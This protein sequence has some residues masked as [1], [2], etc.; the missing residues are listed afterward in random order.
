MSPQQVIEIYQAVSRLMSDMAQAAQA[1]SWERLRE[2]ESQCRTLTHTLMVEEANVEL[3]AELRREKFDL[4]RR[5]LDDDAAI[6]SVTQSWMSELEVLIGR[7]GMQRKL[8][9]AYGA[10]PH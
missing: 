9:V 6:R 7:T 1:H 3:P 2:L 5:I 4:L 8:N 10:G